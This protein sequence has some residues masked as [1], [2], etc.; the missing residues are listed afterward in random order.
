MKQKLLR[1][2]IDMG[3]GVRLTAPIKLN[4]TVDEWQRMNVH[5]NS[6]IKNQ[7]VTQKKLMEQLHNL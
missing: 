5:I 3:Y 1:M 4:M 7:V 2:T 6:L